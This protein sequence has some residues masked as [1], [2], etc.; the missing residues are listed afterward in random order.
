MMNRADTKCP[1]TSAFTAVSGI[2]RCV[3]TVGLGPA[4]LDPQDRVYASSQLSG[5]QA[6]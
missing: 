2:L 3:G 6:A 1:L 4:T 5:I